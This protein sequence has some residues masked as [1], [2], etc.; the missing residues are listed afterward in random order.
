MRTGRAAG[1]AAGTASAS[2]HKAQE[3]DFSGSSPLTL[4]EA[5]VAMRLV[6]AASVTVAL[7]AVSAAGSATRPTPAALIAKGTRPALGLTPSREGASTAAVLATCAHGA[8]A[9]AERSAP[10]LLA[11]WSRTSP[12]SGAPTRSPR[13]LDA[14][15]DARRERATGSRT[16]AVG[17]SHPDLTGDDGVV[18]RCF[19]SHGYVFHPLANFAKLNAR[20]R[21]RRRRRRPSELAAALLARATRV[22][23]EARL[24]VRVPVR[25][26]PRA[27][28]VRDGAGRR[29]A[30]ARPRRR[31]AQRPGA[32][33]RGRR[34]LRRGARAALAVARPPSRGSRSTASTAS[35]VLNAQL[36]AALSVGD[37]AEISGDPDAQ[38][39]ADRLTAAAAAPPAALRHGL[40]VPL[41]A[42]W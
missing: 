5:S 3:Q 29:R 7:L 23:G 21:G 27:V 19:W 34:G 28:D 38:A 8:Q 40:L 37:Y 17:G 36:Q 24:G 32:P 31:P 39:F 12:R 2:A 33:R 16:H 10:M 11:A 41:L 18:Y 20:G 6:V 42:P 22:G 14:L 9:A 30:G 15:L 13:A 26:R 4:P 25:L 1:S 35:P